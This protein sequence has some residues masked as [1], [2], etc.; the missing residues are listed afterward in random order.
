MQQY[1]RVQTQRLMYL[2]VLCTPFVTNYFS[3]E[4]TQNCALLSY[5]ILLYYF[6]QERI[7]EGSVCD[8]EK[9]AGK[10]FERSA[11]FKNIYTTSFFFLGKISNIFGC[12]C[13]CCL[14]YLKYCQGLVCVWARHRWFYILFIKV[15]FFF[16]R[17]F[18]RLFSLRLYFF[19]RHVSEMGL[20]R[21]DD[22]NILLRT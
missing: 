11:S 3:P 21:A 16:V 12:Y 4:F 9:H 1:F 20:R 7:K 8:R 22:L 2:I 10:S 6:Q 13:C 17:F 18:V 15:I 14:F 5:T 19:L